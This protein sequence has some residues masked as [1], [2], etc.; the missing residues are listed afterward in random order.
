MATRKKYQQYIKAT[1]L[2]ELLGEL[3]YIGTQLQMENNMAA[4]AIVVKEFPFITVLL[5]ETEERM[6]ADRDNIG[7]RNPEGRNERPVR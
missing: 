5:T 6:P 7:I 1:G 4:E 2:S 3:V